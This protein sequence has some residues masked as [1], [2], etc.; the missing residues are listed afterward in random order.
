MYTWPLERPDMTRPAVTSPS[1]I[2][3]CPCRHGYTVVHSNMRTERVCNICNT[4]HSTASVNIGSPEH[5]WRQGGFRSETGQALS[6]RGRLH[7]KNRL[8]DQQRTRNKLAQTP[9]EAT[10]SECPSPGHWLSHK[11]SV[12]VA[13]PGPHG[14]SLLFTLW[15]SR[16]VEPSGKRQ[17]RPLAT[18]PLNTEHRSSSQSN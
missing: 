14:G 18:L 11:E 13:C 16:S 8:C 2:K 12:C 4:L 15:L 9:F 7:G 10:G 1:P 5:W 6:L 3:G 17:G